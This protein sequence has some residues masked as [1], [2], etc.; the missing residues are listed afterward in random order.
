MESLAAWA[1]GPRR[2][3]L[4]DGLHALEYRGYDSAGI[5]VMDGET[6]SVVK[7]KGR[8]DRLEEK[9]REHPLQGTM[10][11][12][13]TRWATH[14]EPSDVNSH[15]HTSMAGDIALVH[16]GIIEKLPGDQ[17]L[18]DGSRLP[19]CQ[20]YRYRSGGPS[21]E[22]LRPRRPGAG[23]APGHDQASGLL[24]SGGD[25]GAGAGS[26]RLRTKGQPLVIGLGE[27]E[28]FIASDI[29]ALLTHTR[30]VILLEDGDVAVVTRER[31]HVVDANLDPV[32]LQPFHVDWDVSAAEKG[33]YAH[34]M[35]KE[36]MEQPQ[37]IR[38]T[39]SPRVRDG[40]IALSEITEEALSAARRVVI[41]AC[42][43]AYHAGLVGKYIM[44]DLARIPVE[45]D[46][47]SEYRYRRPIIHGDDLCIVISQ[48]GETA[49]TIATLRTMKEGGAR[50]LAITNVVGSTV[51]READS[52][53]Y[54]WAGPEIAVASTK[55]YTTQLA[56]LVL[57]ALE[58]GRVR[59]TVEEAAYREILT[60]LTEVP[61]RIQEILQDQG[62]VQRAAGRH[63][64]HRDVFFIGRGLDY[65][66]TME[67]SLKLKEISY[68]HSEAMAA[69]E[70][71]HGTIAMIEEEPWS[72]P[73]APRM[74]SWKRWSPPSGR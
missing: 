19:L 28:N 65:P 73:Y 46:I 57:L 2:L 50:V 16:N 1:N 9:L 55:A 49:D 26:D 42:G 4:L 18:A 8:V 32:E 12:G 40:R 10:G 7:T 13:H 59:G 63:F 17:T 30:E 48:S 69:G 6:V 31:V 58:L 24:C 20:R 23:A 47:G 51:A 15:P 43:T 74:F 14:G 29:P 11:I 56:A 25:V 34:F 44:E 33:G 35:L 66:A 3:L 61:A 37:A 45:V 67:S 62:A 68:I 54:T 27:G 64:H 60:A 41:C 21:G 36:M 53:L 5:A 72:S 52:V 70:L 38:E 71:K 39:V 22:P